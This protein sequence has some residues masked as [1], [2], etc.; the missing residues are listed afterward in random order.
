[1]SVMKVTNSNYTQ[2]VL[3]SNVPVLIDFFRRLVHAL[4]DVCAN[5]R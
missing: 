4:Q 2:E 5:C 1:M 3:E